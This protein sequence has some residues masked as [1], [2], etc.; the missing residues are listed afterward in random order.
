MI[1]TRSVEL[2]I[3][4]GVC[5]TLAKRET[6]SGQFGGYLRVPGYQALA[7]SLIELEKILLTNKNPKTQRR[8]G[9]NVNQAR[10]RCRMGPQLRRWR[11]C[12]LALSGAVCLAVSPLSHT[13][14]FGSLGIGLVA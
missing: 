14:G 10:V 12:V 13:S 8:V 1:S 5:L 3:D 4:T 11:T 2:V 6:V 7:R 9:P